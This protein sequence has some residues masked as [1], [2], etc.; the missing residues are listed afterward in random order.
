MPQTSKPTS[1]RKPQRRRRPVSA[2]LFTGFW[3]DLSGKRIRR[4]RRDE[5]G[6]LYSLWRR[7]TAARL[8]IVPVGMKGPWHE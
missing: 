7:H 2:G 8:G 4:I 6:E 5:Y 1:E 3:T